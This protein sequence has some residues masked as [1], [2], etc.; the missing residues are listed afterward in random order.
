MLAQL[1]SGFTV[2]EKTG[3]RWVFYMNKK[4]YPDFKGMVKCFHKAG[5]KVVPNV[6]P[7]LFPSPPEPDIR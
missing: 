3:S 5:M 4:R 1:S 7:C 6:K 2:D